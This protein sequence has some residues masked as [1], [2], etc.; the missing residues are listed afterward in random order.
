M[1]ILTFTPQFPPS[2]GG[3]E[4]LTADLVVDLA[5]RGHH[6]EVVTSSEPGDLP[7]SDDWHGVP[8]HR[9][10]LH[11]PLVRNDLRRIAGIRRDFAALKR[12]VD[13]DVL[14]VH[15]ADASVLYH[16]LTEHDH[17]V[18]TVLTVHSSV[19]A[20]EARPDTVLHRALS[21]VDAL[22]ACSQSML[23]QVLATVPGVA[24]RARVVL[25]GIDSGR[26]TPTPLPRGDPSVLVL[27]RM[28]QWKGFDVALGAAALMVPEFPSLRVVLVGDGPERAA[29]GE[30]VEA[31]G[32]AEHV[33]TPG[34]LPIDMVSSV[35]E[36]ST[37]VAVPS[38]YPEPFGIVAVEAG[39]ANRPVVASAVG[40]LPEIVVDGLNGFLVPAD[41]PGAL[42]EALARVLRDR[43]LAEALAA[44]GRERALGHFSMTRH[45]DQIE[46][47]YSQLERT[48]RR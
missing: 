45:A 39:L 9:L 47:V 10:A 27:G 3:L 35:Y 17:P 43:A 32:L 25:N 24:P 21:T 18:P 16:V 19:A 13:P 20:S 46:A 8:V 1:R 44:A 34:A 23:D 4:S 12:S 26:V 22:T 41:D 29:L 11:S 14:H 5:G 42:A 7:A 31:Y 30:L 48:V 6:V 15:L 28:V 36:R 38:R 33:E 37:V 40:G 2:V